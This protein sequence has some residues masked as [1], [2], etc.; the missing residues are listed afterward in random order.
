MQNQG[1]KDGG[2]S[3]ETTVQTWDRVLDLPKGIG[4]ER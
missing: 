4:G 1:G 2:R 3:Q